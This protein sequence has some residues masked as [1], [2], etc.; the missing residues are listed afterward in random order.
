MQDSV[1]KH[2]EIRPNIIKNSADSGPV[3]QGV[4]ELLRA[5][6]QTVGNICTETV[7]SV[8]IGDNE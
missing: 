3:D 5:I 1:R 6:E 8:T 4:V 2:Y 7:V